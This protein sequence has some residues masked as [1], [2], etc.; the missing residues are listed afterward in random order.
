MATQK[1]LQVYGTQLLFAD[2]A[3]DFGAAP[4]T[5]ANSLIIGSPT[6]VRM[7]LSVVAAAAGWQSAK[8]ATLAHTGTA[9]PVEW[10][11]G[12]CIESTATPAAGATFEFW[13]NPSPSATAGT[14]NAGGASGADASYA[15]AGKTQ[16]MHLGTMV[17]VANVININPCIARVRLPYLYGSLI[18]INSTA[19]AMVAD[20]NADEIHITL[21][22]VLLDIQAAA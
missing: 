4:A 15:V 14:G 8:T 13:W 20:A 5:A 16:L 11:L 17:T 3:T 21:T 2:H 18:F 12:A 19:V 22:P 1:L 7:N 9:M 6:D 10:I